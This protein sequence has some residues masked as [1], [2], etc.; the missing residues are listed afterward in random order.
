MVRGAVFLPLALVVEELHVAIY[1]REA[2]PIMAQRA[3]QI[4]Y[5]KETLARIKLTPAELQ[6][7]FL[8]QGLLGCQPLKP[9]A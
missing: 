8:E 9:T 6:V 1:V 5:L 4:V 7:A 2:A 3:C